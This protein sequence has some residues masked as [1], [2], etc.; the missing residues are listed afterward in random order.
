VLELIFTGVDVTTAAQ[1]FHVAVCTVRRWK[2]IFDAFGEI[3]PRRVRIMS[4]VHGTVLDSH[5]HYAIV[6]LGKRPTQYYQEL[7]DD[8][9]LTFGVVYT[10]SQLFVALK[11]AGITRKVFL[12]Y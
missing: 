11:F 9:F 8:I 12:I 1:A 3:A 7:C 2:I 6:E 4:G 5:L 10:Q